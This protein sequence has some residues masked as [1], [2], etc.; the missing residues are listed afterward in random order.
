[1]ANVAANVEIDAP[2]NV[3]EVPCSER[4]KYERLY[5]LRRPRG[6]PGSGARGTTTTAVPPA[7]RDKQKK[8]KKERKG[9]CACE[10]SYKI[11]FE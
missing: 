9:S 4:S 10:L 2:A 11:G 1:M 8:T 3:A 7:R 5:P 6:R